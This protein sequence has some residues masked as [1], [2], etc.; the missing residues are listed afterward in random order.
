[1]HDEEASTARVRMQV[2]GNG[3]N[4]NLRFDDWNSSEARFTYTYPIWVLTA[5]HQPALNMPRQIPETI[6]ATIR[7]H[8]L[9]QIRTLLLE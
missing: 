8:C 7:L 3:Y 9:I 1:M 6:V 4:R 5:L 2:Q